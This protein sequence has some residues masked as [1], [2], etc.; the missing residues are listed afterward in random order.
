[1]A[2]LL[3]EGRLGAAWAMARDEARQEAGDGGGDARSAVAIL[4]AALRHRLTPDPPRRRWQVARAATLVPPF[5]DPA[6]AHRIDLAGRLRADARAAFRP[7][8]G[9]G[10]DFTGWFRAGREVAPRERYDRIAGDA[11]IEARDPYSDPEVIRFGLSLPPEQRRRHGLDKALQRRAMAGLLPE[12]VL[13]NDR[14]AH[15]GP[16]F[17]RRVRPASAAGGLP[18]EVRGYLVPL[19][20]AAAE[21]DEMADWLAASAAALSDWLARHRP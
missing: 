1:M 17:A 8:L 6:F 18:E 7:K 21:E 14:R 15:L 5:V 2:D 19:K 9:A 11:G 16:A 12:A 4:G 3:G 10:S 20:G 13:S